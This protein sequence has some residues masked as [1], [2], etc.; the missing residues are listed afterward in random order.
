MTINEFLANPMNY[1]RDSMYNHK[2]VECNDGFSMSVQASEVH[3]CDPRETHANYYE[4]VEIGFP[5]EKEELLLEYAEEPDKPT[6]TVYGYVPVELVDEII[7]KHGGFK[8]V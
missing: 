6:H 5:S 7:Q 3:Y 8:E 1:A 2:R 4:S